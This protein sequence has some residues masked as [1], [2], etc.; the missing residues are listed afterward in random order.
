M[1]ALTLLAFL[2]FL[3]ILQQCIKEHMNDL[4]ASPIV[5][6]TAGKDG[7]TN[8]AKSA[9]K[10]DKSGVSEISAKQKGNANENRNPTIEK[11]EAKNPFQNPTSN[12]KLLKVP[13]AEKA[14]TGDY[15]RNQYREIYKNYNNGNQSPMFSRYISDTNEDEL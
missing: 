13:L 3:H 9:N 10:I 1:S 15:T 12:K 8:I 7:E 5:V 2:F 14:S 11:Y 4:G 6:M